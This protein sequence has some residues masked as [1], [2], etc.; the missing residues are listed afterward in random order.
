MFLSEWREFPSAPC[1]A[2]K[3]RNL[4]TARVSMLLK[5]RSPLHASELVSFLVGLRTYQHPAIVTLFN[6]ILFPLTY[7]SVIST[8][9]LVVKS[10]TIIRNDLQW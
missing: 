2:E 10:F 1:L 6:I 3:K 4:L 8:C 5:S 9:E 7:I